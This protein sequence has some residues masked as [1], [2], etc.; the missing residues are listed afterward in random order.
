[1]KDFIEGCLKRQAH[2]ISRKLPGRMLEL[3]ISEGDFVKKGQI[4]ALLDV[5]E[6]EANIA[7][8]TWGF[9]S[10]IYSI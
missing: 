1:M 5:P 10:L 4:L 8:S 6:I 3:R 9:E 2:S 7:S